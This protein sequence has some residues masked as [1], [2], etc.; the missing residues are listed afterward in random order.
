MTLAVLLS[1]QGGQHPGMFDLTADWPAAAPVFAAAERLLGRD[2]RDLVRAPGADLPGAD[3]PGADLHDNRTGQILCC[4][5]ALAGW[6]VVEAARPARVVVA[7]YS[8]GDLAAWGCAGRFDVETILR[9]AAA[10]AE[11][12]D[13]AGGEG[14]G[15]AGLRGLPLARI[16][17]LA[18]RHGCHLAIR[19]AAD[20][21]VVGGARA[22]L[23]ALCTEARAAGAL[24][25]VI[26]AVRTPSH[27]PLLAQASR[28][29]DDILR[30]ETPQRPKPGAPR[31]ISGLDGAPVFDTEA[32][33]AKLTRQIAHTID[34]AACLE[35]CREFGSDTVLELGPGHALST[36]ARDLT[37]QWR[38]HA[39]DEF[40]SAAG[41][42]AW[43]GSA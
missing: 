6:T 39:L 21:A 23:E 8:I 16:E 29:F 5:A 20:S 1:G 18:E 43:I 33:L 35:A 22:A 11:V 41:A 30:R 37:P 9:L 28:R 2:P 25:A 4:V 12:M 15:L 27:T 17:R 14:F 40:R 34:W 26:L 10:R 31:L 38:V 32:G 3:L 19:N 36:M 13:A 7:G 24:R 42:V